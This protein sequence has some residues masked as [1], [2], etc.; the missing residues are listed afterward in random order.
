MTLKSKIF[1]LVLFMLFALVETPLA[2][3]IMAFPSTT[4]QAGSGVTLSYDSYVGDCIRWDFG[5]G[6][7]RVDGTGPEQ[8]THIYTTPGTYTVRAWDTYCD[9][10]GPETASQVITVINGG[11]VDP[12]DDGPFIG[13][14]APFAVAFVEPRFKDGSSYLNVAKDSRGVRAYVDIKCEGSGILRVQW[15]VDDNPLFIQ[16]KSV[17]FAGK[18][19]LDSGIDLPTMI[20]GNHRVSIRILSPLTTLS[21]P[22]INYYV[23]AEDQG[24]KA[25]LFR[26]VEITIDKTTNN[27]GE[28]QPFIG[29]ILKGKKNDYTI[30][31]GT[32]INQGNTPIP[33]GYLNAYIDSKLVATQTI[34]LIPPGG[35]IPFDTSIKFPNVQKSQLELRFTDVNGQEIDAAKW[36]VNTEALLDPDY[37]AGDKDIVSLKLHYITLKNYLV[38]KTN[39]NKNPV[40]D[41]DTYIEGA[42][43]VTFTVKGTTIAS[44]AS[45]KKFKVDTKL[46]QVVYPS[47][48][49]LKQVIRLSNTNAGGEQILFDT[50]RDRTTNGYYIPILVEAENA[51]EHLEKTVYQYVSTTAHT[52]Q[53][54]IHKFTF[55]HTSSNLPYRF[56]KREHVDDTKHKPYDPSFV[57]ITDKERELMTSRA[58]LYHDVSGADRIEIINLRTG[59]MY[60]QFKDYTDLIGVDY[61]GLAAPPLLE[62]GVYQLRAYSSDDVATAFA[63]VTN[64]NVVHKT[65]LDWMI[66]HGCWKWKV[67][68]RG[69]KVPVPK[70]TG[71]SHTDD[72]KCDKDDAVKEKIKK[73]YGQ[74]KPHIDFRVEGGANL[75]RLGTSVRLLAAISDSP[76]RALQNDTKLTLFDLTS[77]K[78]LHTTTLRHCDEYSMSKGYFCRHETQYLNQKSHKLY[79]YYDTPTRPTTYRLVAENTYGKTTAELTV[80]IKDYEKFKNPKPVIK[81]FV[82]KNYRKGTKSDLLFVGEP[83][84]LA[85]EFENADS[86]YILATSGSGKSKEVYLHA[87]AWGGLTK[88]EEVFYPQENTS[89]QLVVK[90]GLSLLNSAVLPVVVTPKSEKN[91]GYSITLK[92]YKMTIF[93]GEESIVS[94]RFSGAK[95][96]YLYVQGHYETGF[97]LPVDAKGSGSGQREFRPKMTTSYVLELLTEDGKK[98][99]ETITVVVN[100]SKDSVISPGIEGSLVFDPDAPLISSFSASPESIR[101]PVNATAN[102]SLPV[103]LSYRFSS[104]QKARIVERLSGKTIKELKVANSG[105]TSGS[106]KL[107]PDEMSVYVLEIFGEDG[108]KHSAEATVK[109]AR[110]MEHK[111]F[112][113]KHRYAPTIMAFKPSKEEVQPGDLLKLHYKYHEVDEAYIIDQATNKVLHILPPEHKGEYLSGEV[114]VKVPE[115][116]TTATYSWKLSLKNDYKAKSTTATVR[117]IQ[118]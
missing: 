14:S 88:G 28:V 64:V 41:L 113:K 86:A 81:S 72:I 84:R 56:K 77:S 117:V 67:D 62:A 12:G 58:F 32:I 68:D 115:T 111:R 93:A 90:K 23:A 87:E 15:F 80:D 20:P 16:S 100:K 91:P 101:L 27:L 78:Q 6:S 8:M 65:L 42:T 71:M 106:L 110:P 98:R 36:G 31:S 82:T 69:Q 21:I 37:K 108:I 96:A 17:N 54:I 97:D 95:K 92:A 55:Q 29:N 112:G 79:E 34:Q 10:G 61:H 19:S 25:E 44:T 46:K 102:T 57:Y 85:Y 109:V 33:K 38:A 105:A 50:Q 104:A 24:I 116:T 47:G 35:L 2:A 75:I 73:F 1:F 70:Y 89:Y 59:K 43:K 94:W 3:G 74:V 52:G 18:V 103:T 114:V 63:T 53:P 45:N 30:L 118:P 66:T 9:D 99:A 4:T 7:A 40:I 107:K 39:K 26:N 49:V 76:S 13:P 5:D 11:P 51:T 22:D 83:C 60:D 48:D